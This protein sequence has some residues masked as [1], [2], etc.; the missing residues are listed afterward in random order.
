VFAQ[1]QPYEIEYA[2]AE[3]YILLSK[4]SPSGEYDHALLS[5]IGLSEFDDDISLWESTGNYSVSIVGAPLQ[6]ILLG[7]DAGNSITTG[8]Y[9]F[10]TG[11]NLPN[12]ASTNYNTGIG[13]RNLYTT[14][15]ADYA[16][17]IGRENMFSA[18]SADYATGIGRENM[19]NATNAVYATGIGNRNMY[20]ATNAIYATG[21]GYQNMYNST[22]AI[23][24]TGI[25]DENMYSATSAD[26]ATGI[27][28]E[29]MYNA[30]SATN[31]TGIGRRNMYSATNA[32]YATG[33]GDRNMYSTT[34]AAYTTGIGYAN[35]YSATNALYATGIGDQNM[36]NATDAF[37]ATGI[38]HENLFSATSANYATGIGRQNM[39]NA[40]SATYATGIGDR[41]MYNATSANYA[42]GIGFV[43][44]Y[45]AT[46]ANYAT[47]IGYANMYSATNAVYATGIGYQNMYNATN[48]VYATGIGNRNINSAT[49]AR[50]ATGIGSENLFSATSA[51]FSTGIGYRN[52]YN[53]TSADYVTGIGGQNMFN[54]TSALNATGIGRENMYLASSADYSTG[55]GDRNMY[56]A[57]SADYATGIGELNMYSATNA[58]YA[59][60]IGRRNMYLA[61]SAGYATGIG[62]A[63]MFNA[64]SAAYAT[65]IGLQNMYNATSADYSIAIGR[66]NGYNAASQNNSIYLGYRQAYTTG[67][68]Y[69]LH[70]GMYED[71]PL[72]YGEFDN[73]EVEIGGKLGYTTEGGSAVSLIGKDATDKLTTT[74]VGDLVKANGLWTESG[75]DI[76]RNT[77]NVG[78][79]TSSATVPL[80]VV[81]TVG[82]WSAYIN[83]DVGTGTQSG[84]LLDAGSSS[85]DFAMYVRNAAAS[86]DL[87]SIKGT[88]NVGIGTSSPA[89]PL[90]INQSYPQI[91]LQSTNDNTY[92]KIGSGTGYMVWDIINPTTNTYQWRNSGSAQMTINT[93]GNVGIGTS[94]PRSILETSGTIS[95]GDDQTTL[96]EGT[97]VS[98]LDFYTSDPSFASSSTNK[99][100]R[101]FPYSN[102][103]VGQGFGL[104]FSTSPDDTDAEVKMTI[105]KSGNVGIG[106]T[107]PGTKLTIENASAGTA[108]L[109]YAT[110]VSNANLHLSAVGVPFYNHLFMGVGSA[111][112]AWIQSQHGNSVAQDLALNPIGGNVGIGTTT[113][114]EAMDVVGNAEI[115]GELFVTDAISSGGSVD[116]QLFL[117]S[118]DQ[119]IERSIKYE[120]G[121][122]RTATKV[123]GT[124]STD[125][126][127]WTEM[128]DVDNKYSISSASITI[129]TNG[130]YKI[131]FNA[132]ITGTTQTKEYEVQLWNATDGVQ[133]RLN[134]FTLLIDATDG[135]DN[136]HCH[137]Q[138]IETLT[139]SKTYKIRMKERTGNSG[140][141]LLVDT[142]MSI[143]LKAE[144]S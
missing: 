111:T 132:D 65:G 96:V 25:G 119:V 52:M 126:D 125:I 73:E 86:S 130:T 55:I 41:N 90:H 38:G 45:N 16:T 112:H 109:T 66:E 143:E 6:N 34:N 67:A 123:I 99:I 63:N 70:I 79:G 15:S 144:A 7:T 78:I 51:E 93:L 44:M 12:T 141:L 32:S 118:N 42:T 62:F 64:T 138:F 110:T 136:G 87:F 88:G 3:K 85:S 48:A 59:T 17:G 108:S 11:T 5:S 54:A 75:S 19:Y 61:T 142:S 104:K 131:S 57:T 100:A 128:Y 115:N 103:S 4:L 114:S 58:V 102:S 13:Y 2:T 76:Y 9:N 107:S 36:Y 117:T 43:N 80:H 97:E 120:S 101:I 49:N 71:N 89:S 40:T 60:G 22:S 14:F 121:Y 129:P 84:L 92:T 81:N 8:N 23:Y 28:H 47:G 116:A 82:G 135:V 21:I 83:N 27:G 50:Y 140:S 31:A 124:T 1:V 137:A 69:R 46:S 77:G 56:L 133:V 98:G 18:T 68:N 10:I 94:S 105:D 20:N 91:R 127:G 95:I 37:Y 74:D 139:A 106:T 29:N 30:S 33:I 53:A 35:M 24:A 134:E 39:Y 122:R 72:I 26:Y 113:P